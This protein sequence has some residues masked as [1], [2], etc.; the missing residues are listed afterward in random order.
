[1]AEFDLFLLVSDAQGTPAA[2]PRPNSATCAFLA[3]DSGLNEVEE[4][5]TFEPLS[6]KSFVPHFGQKWK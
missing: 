5:A 1:M 4:A 2:P 6:S 3:D